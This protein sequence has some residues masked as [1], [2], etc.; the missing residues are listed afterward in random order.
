MKLL[1]AVAALAVTYAAVEVGGLFKS[2]SPSASAIAVK[3]GSTSCTPMDAR[4][5]VRLSG[6]HQFVQLYDCV[7]ANR[8]DECLAL[9]NGRILNETGFAR[10]MFA[11]GKS[12]SASKANGDLIPPSA[13]ASP[14][15][16]AKWPH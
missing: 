13:F 2:G 3:A 16:C 6:G 7:F 10:F 15:K 12:A 14:P 9:N 11:L 5:R 1:V 4:A 8:P